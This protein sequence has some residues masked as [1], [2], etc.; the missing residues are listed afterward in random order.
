MQYPKDQVLWRVSVCTL[1]QKS[2][3]MHLHETETEE[4]AAQYSAGLHAK[5]MERANY[6][7]ESRYG[8]NAVY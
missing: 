6:V 5:D 3:P 8:G 1:R 7:G 4:R 2:T